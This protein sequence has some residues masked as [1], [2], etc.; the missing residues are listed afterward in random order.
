MH[1]EI[2]IPGVH[3]DHHFYTMNIPIEKDKTMGIV[4]I[5][6]LLLTEGMFEE[7]VHS[8]VVDT[9]LIVVTVQ[10]VCFV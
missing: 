2:I 3:L 7:I 5:G 6:P 8:P 4:M 1:S 10:C 9:N